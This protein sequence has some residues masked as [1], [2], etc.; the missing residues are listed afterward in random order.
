[1]RQAL[2]IRQEKTETNYDPQHPRIQESLLK[3]DLFSLARH[4]DDTIDYCGT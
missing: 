1:M 4:R 3:I 2:N